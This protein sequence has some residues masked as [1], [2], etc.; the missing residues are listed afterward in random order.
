MPV[1]DQLEILLEILL[2]LILGGLIGF[3]RELKDKPAGL[4][5][6]MLAAGS[7]ALFIELGNFVVTEFD[8]PSFVTTDP[9]RIIQAIIVG[10]SFLGAGT[11]LQRNDGSSVE[12][13][14]TAA[15][16]LAAAGVGMSSAMRLFVLA[17]GMTA[18]ILITN[19][20]LG[21]LEARYLDRFQSD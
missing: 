14:T 16:I 21:F 15:S 20:L 4:R 5:T 8:Y 9:I 11:I 6:H 12:G 7:A 10:I 2:A 17:A 18:L 19:R 3:E 1:S 13:L